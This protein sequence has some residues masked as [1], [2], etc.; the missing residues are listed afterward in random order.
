M[1]FAQNISY[2]KKSRKLTQTDIA[3]AV[4]LSNQMISAYE[5]GGS[6]PNL[7]LIQQLADFFG[8]PAHDLVFVDLSRNESIVA[9]PRAEYNKRTVRLM[10][11]ELDRLEALEKELKETPGALDA[12]RKIAPELVRKIEQN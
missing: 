10:E 8:V 2:L 1:F 7:K 3:N 12:L 5:N 6:S 4:G 11:K 9:E